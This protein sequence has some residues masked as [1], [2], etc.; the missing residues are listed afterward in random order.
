MDRKDTIP[1]VIGYVLLCALSVLL[2]KP[3][4]AIAQVSVLTQHNDNLRTGGN[5][6][7]T[8]LN[9][10]N[11]NV[12]SFGKLFTLPVDG[13]TYAQPLYVPGVSI[14]GGTH[15][16]VYVATA[17]DS[18]YAFD[19]DTGALYWQ[20]SLGTSVPS[21]V[22]NTPNIQVEVGIIST[23]VIDP[24]TNTIY[25]VA[26]TYE[27]SVQIFR[28][29]ALN[30]STGV[31]QA[32]SPVVISATGPGTGD[33][34]DGA[35]NIPFVAAKENQRAAVTLVNGVL[36]LAFASH[37]DYDPYH[38]WVLAYSESTLQQVAAYDVTPNGGRG[39]IWM[40]GQGL[41]ADAA[42]FLYLLSGNSTQ[43]EENSVADYGESF[44]KLG[45]AGNTLSE[46]D[47]FKPNNYDFLNANDIDLGSGGPVGIPGTT[48][49]VG[50]GKQ[51]YLYVVNT[52]N[53]GQLNL[54]ADS[55][56][57]EWQA[58][59][60]VWGSPVFWNSTTPTL[61]VWS[62]NDTLKA[63]SFNPATGLF[64]TTPSSKSSF[65]SSTGNGCLAL[66]V[67]SNGSTA[68]TGI[69]WAAI[70]NG[71]PDHATVPGTL[72]AF[73]ASNL[74]TPIW[75][76]KQDASRDDFGNFA[77][78]DAPTVANGKVYLGTDSGQVV[79]YGEL[80]VNTGG[81]FT[82]SANPSSLSVAQANHGTTTIS[83][84]DLNG[85]TGSVAL[86]ATNLPSGVTA[87]FSPT[88]TAGTST[89]TI[90]ATNIATVGST[91]IT[92]IGASGSLNH[93]ITLPLTITAT[94]NY[95]IPNGTYTITCH[96]SGYL[97]D[98]FGNGTANGTKVIQWVANGGNNQQWVVVNLGSN[99]VTL[100]NVHS[101]LLMEVVGSSTSNG[102]L[103]DQRSSTGGSNQKWKI[104]SVG[105]G[106]FTLTNQKSGKVLDDPG[107]STTQGTQLEQW[108]LNGGTNQQ[109]FFK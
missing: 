92:I 23:P 15:N 67:S 96:S 106:Y 6:N 50:G 36:Y 1:R 99:V 46:V 104:A 87:T 41:V 51:G 31:E 109:W 68:N 56:I 61:Y 95:L 85:F 52:A 74:T 5:L 33:G 54:S 10:T 7:E 20:I 89:L 69:L 82:L 73:N 94:G 70:P 11:V 2:L 26:K 88:S 93:A 39:G 97:V 105:S 12:T 21:S 16:V 8:T 27:N 102:A 81:D 60:G 35:G 101:G 28:L 48:E 40:G 66:S 80:P 83:V 37:E 14:A 29:H 4:P 65:L 43:S 58:D 45:L 86:S 44:L 59:N 25:V 77:K 78:F 62:Q 100:K 108:T 84:G 24:A 55:V 32:G 79:V 13:F 103:I 90:S 42:G 91:T 30:I 3:M 38:G 107:F 76:S 19:A 63:Y 9:T 72:Y 57:Q 53:M 71:D 22:I 17:H 18:V 34:N 98:D 75:N 49:L 64:A 47:Y